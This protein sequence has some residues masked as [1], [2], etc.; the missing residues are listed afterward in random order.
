MFYDWSLQKSATGT[1]NKLILMRQFVSGTL[2][3]ISYLTTHLTLRNAADVL[4]NSI[5]PNRI[6]YEAAVRCLLWYKTRVG[7]SDTSVND[8]LN[9]YQG[10]AQ[11][12]NARF[13]PAYPPRSAKT[14]HL[15]LGRP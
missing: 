15:S 14:I 5:H 11:E 10:M 4:D 6:L 1:A 7:D 2:L 8:L 9:I 3:R 13:A 12:M